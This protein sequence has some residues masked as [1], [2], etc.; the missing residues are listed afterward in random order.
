[1]KITPARPLTIQKEQ[2]RA[3]IY[4]NAYRILGT[5][6]LQVGGRVS[7][8]VNWNLK[9]GPFVPLTD[10]SVYTVDTGELL[11]TTEFLAVHRNQIN[12]LAIDKMSPP[13]P[14]RR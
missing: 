3:T 14:S 13:A 1:M 5:V 4:L 11:F 7:D 6:H 10:A 2:H 9:E 12:F 8:F